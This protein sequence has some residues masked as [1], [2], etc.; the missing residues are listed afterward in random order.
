MQ[1]YKSRLDSFSRQKRL[2]QSTTKR[3]VAVKWPHAEDILATPD[4]LAEA[5]FFW[6]PTYDDRDNVAC[7]LCGKELAGWEP[8]D[9][10]HVV[11]YDKCRDVCA[12]A[13][14]RC[15]LSLDQDQFGSYVFK[16]A[17]RHPAGKTMEKARLTTFKTN[18]W[19]PHDSA[20]GHGASSTKM[21]KAGFVYTPTSPGDDTAT[22]LY[23]GVSL[24]GWEE[25][26]NPVYAY[27]LSPFLYH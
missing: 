18:D 12:W 23:C 16:D 3:S 24:N 2:K 21:A 11:H 9:D 6:A 17:S 13:A 15:G 5:G 19:W 27:T 10:P 22:C 8:D 4:T 14:V 26:D 1:V 25:D 7:F 20:K